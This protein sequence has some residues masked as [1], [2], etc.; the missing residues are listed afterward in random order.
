MIIEERL[1]RLERLERYEDL[2]TPE[3]I[4]DKFAELKKLE[5]LLATL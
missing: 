3:Q 5:S 2:G 1:E 4:R